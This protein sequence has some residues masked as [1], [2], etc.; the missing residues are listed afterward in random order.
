MWEKEVALKES[1]YN[2]GGSMGNMA[3]LGNQICSA[4]HCTQGTVI[5]FYVYA[6]ECSDAQYFYVHH[7]TLDMAFA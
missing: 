3:A 1:Q 2:L 7:L 4:A 6:F 5:A